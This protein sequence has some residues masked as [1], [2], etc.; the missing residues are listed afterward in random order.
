[1]QKGQKPTFTG[2]ILPLFSLSVKNAAKNSKKRGH[3]H[4]RKKG[5]SIAGKAIFSAVFIMR[6]PAED[7]FF[8]EQAA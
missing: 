1:L 6:F 2:Y 5:G 8:K 4:I 3:F 7:A